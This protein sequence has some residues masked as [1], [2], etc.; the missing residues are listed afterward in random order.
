WLIEHVSW[1]SAFFVNLPVA[2]L[3]LGILFSRVPES[4]AP[5]PA[6]PLD[7]AGAVLVT[8]GLGGIV[9]ALVES[10]RLG[11]RDPRMWVSLAGGGACMVAFV[12]VEARSRFPMVPL[13]LFRSRSFTGANLLTL[14]LYGALGGV[15]FFLPLDLIQAQR[16][17]A[18]AAGAAGLPFVLVLFLLSRWSGGL[19]DRFGARLPLVV[20]PV[21]A[22]GGYALL[23]LPG[24]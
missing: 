18:T 7:W 1:R 22:A 5:K 11:W 10:S 9:Y 21:I 20:G 12:T 16:Y 4:R 3:V 2:V 15:F 23:A 13:A 6:G 8:F 14:L 17:S 24:L 19:L